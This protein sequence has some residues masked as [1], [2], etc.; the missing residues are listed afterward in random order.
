MLM[1]WAGDILLVL[2]NR[3]T[4]RDHEWEAYLDRCEEQVTRQRRTTTRLGQLVVTQGGAPNLTQRRTAQRRV[5]NTDVPVA[6][7]SS[8]AFV[9][10]VVDLLV[11]S[12][13]NTGVRGF[14]TVSDALAY[15]DVDGAIR[16]TVALR[17][18]ELAME[19]EPPPPRR[20]MVWRR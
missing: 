14:A 18:D 7:V 13:T 10:F 2:H 11:R 12:G 20:S 6:V 1:E 4:P 8:S 3:S 17:V 5:S 19:I 9:R 15:L 16:E